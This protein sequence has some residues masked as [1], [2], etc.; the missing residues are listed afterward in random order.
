[1]PMSLLMGMAAF[2][3]NISRGLFDAV[4]PVVSVQ[5]L[6]WKATDYSNVKGMG[7]LMWSVFGML[8]GGFQIDRFGRLRVMRVVLVMF[9]ALYA[10]MAALSGYWG[11]RGLVTAY[12]MMNEL[13]YT[14]ITIAIFAVAMQLC[15]KRVAAT[16]FTLYMTIFNLGTAFGS[17]LLGPLQSIGGYWFAVLAIAGASSVVL[18]LLRFADLARHGVKMVDLEKEVRLPQ[19]VESLPASADVALDA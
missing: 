9:V 7:S 13:F 19:S 2:S 4:M 12:V 18:L 15:W 3:F 11:H 8:I 10:T 14:L 17:A 5:E 16:Q 6:S 1:M